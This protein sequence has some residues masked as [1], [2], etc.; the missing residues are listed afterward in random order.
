MA[1]VARAVGDWESADAWIET[2]TSVKAAINELLWNDTLGNYA[3]DVKTQ[4]VYGVSAIAFAL[5]SGVANETQIKLCVEGLEGLRQG[6]GYLD[7]SDT[8]NT[9][10]IS[11]NTNG[12]LLD[13]L[14]QH[15]Y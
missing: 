10:K 7:T 2:A 14:L 13:A 9:T 6:P 8:N 3:V 1:R 5:T 15:G 11:P 12:F 4:E